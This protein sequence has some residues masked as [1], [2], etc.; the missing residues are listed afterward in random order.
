MA[1]S[2][3]KLSIQVSYSLIFLLI[4]IRL[5]WGLKKIS[6]ENESNMS[7]FS[8]FQTKIWLK[9]IDEQTIF[10]VFGCS[11]ITFYPD[12]CLKVAYFRH[13]AVIFFMVYASNPM[14]SDQY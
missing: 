1:D 3:Q 8:D 13:V 11:S 5:A 2:C 7:I 6:Q 12:L 10:S 9:V 4:L 14:P